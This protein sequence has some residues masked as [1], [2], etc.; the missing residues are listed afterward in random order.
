[1]KKP[2]VTQALDVVIVSFLGYPPRLF[3]FYHIEDANS[4]PAPGPTLATECP[5]VLRWCLV[6]TAFHNMAAPARQTIDLN[7]M[8]LLTSSFV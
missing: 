8:K 7:N 2:E 6:A 5:V 4:H 1:M 3:F